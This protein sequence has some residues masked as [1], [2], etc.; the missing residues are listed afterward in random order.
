MITNKS[1]SSEN[2]INI[3][4]NIN[5]LLLQNINYSEQKIKNNIISKDVNFSL[6][7][8]NKNTFNNIVINEC[9]KKEKYYNYNDLILKVK[10][11]ASPEEE[12]INALIK[13]IDNEIKTISNKINNTNGV[14][15]GIW[16]ELNISLEK[17]DEELI[18]K[19]TEMLQLLT[20][21]NKDF[22]F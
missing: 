16:S 14:L 19:S 1:L 6:N 9:K 8:T 5:S 4:K 15:F 3:H 12:N 22:G 2:P 13:N 10:P 17:E 18:N 20:E 7:N 11:E 21:Y